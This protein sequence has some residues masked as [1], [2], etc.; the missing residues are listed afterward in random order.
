MTV[1]ELI[2]ELEEYDADSPVR[3]AT[4]PSYPLTNTISGVTVID[5]TLWIATSQ[6]G[7]DESPYAPAEAWSC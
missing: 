3:I 1:G 5:D 4:Q 2:E 7:G 6:V